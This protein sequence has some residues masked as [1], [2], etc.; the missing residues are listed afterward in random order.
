MA[1]LSLT[2]YSGLGA[3]GGGTLL[4]IYL[5][6]DSSQHDVVGM[7]IGS[8]L[9]FLWFLKD[10]GAIGSAFKAAMENASMDG[11][12]DLIRSYLCAPGAKVCPVYACILGSR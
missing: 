7:R 10:L 5:L 8:E 12:V 11:F 2:G 6:S 1:S 4:F 9:A 3:R